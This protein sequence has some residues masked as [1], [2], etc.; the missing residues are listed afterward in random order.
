MKG[1]SLFKKKTVASQKVHVF[2]YTELLYPEVRTI[3][4]SV[5]WL[6]RALVASR[7]PHL[8]DVRYL[9]Q[10]NHERLTIASSYPSYWPTRRL[11]LAGRS[12]SG[13]TATRKPS[14]G[15]VSSSDLSPCLW[16]PV[17]ETEFYNRSRP[18]TFD[19]RKR[20]WWS[21]ISQTCRPFRF[22]RLTSERWDNFPAAKRTSSCVR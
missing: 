8:R 10:A 13:R 3:P 16:K 12:S 14:S 4:S 9:V 19:S 5:I 2:F 17:P 20:V 15:E 1:N 11:Y 6:N 21:K 22:A 18:Q 7:S